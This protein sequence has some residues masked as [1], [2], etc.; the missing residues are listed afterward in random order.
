[1]KKNTS[2]LRK[3]M[4]YAL[5]LIPTISAIMALN[6]FGFFF[7]SGSAGGGILIILLLYFKQLRTRKDIW[8]I[9]AAFLF[10][11]GGDWFL[12]HKHG[13][14]SMFVYGIA[15]FFFA[16]VGYL[17]YALL[18]GRIKWLFTSVLLLGFLLFFFLMLYPGID[19][20]TLMIAALVYLLISCFS[21]G[22]SVG[23]KTETVEKWAYIFGIF[24]ILFSDTIIAFKEFVGYKELNFLILPTYYLAHLTITFS[25]MR[26]KMN[27]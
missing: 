25:L 6:H 13:D 14:A 2:L 16:H 22:A 18:N 21:L 26:K 5:L 8:M 19:D 9:I 4:L 20:K 10:S 27:L 23:I 7:K 3:N 11:I 1:M 12:S 17:V 15:L 24:L